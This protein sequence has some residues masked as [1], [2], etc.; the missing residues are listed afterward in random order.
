MNALHIPTL[1]KPYAPLC[2]DGANALLELAR[3]MNQRATIDMAYDILDRFSEQPLVGYALLYAAAR[4]QGDTYDQ[5][6]GA[7]PYLY[8]ALDV[9]WC[10]AFT[11]EIKDG[12]TVACALLHDVLEDHKATPEELNIYLRSLPVSTP[13]LDEQVLQVLLA[14]IRPEEKN[15]QQGYYAALAQAPSEARLIKAADLICNS[16]SLKAKARIW[17][18]VPPKGAPKPHLIAKYIIEAEKYVLDKPAF[19]TLENYPLI[20]NTLLGILQDL[21]GYLDKEAPAQY[22]LLD[23]LALK[24][25]HTGFRSPA[26]HLKQLRFI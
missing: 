9:A 11:L 14:L 7:V 8:H 2:T 5:A 25:Y 3:D 12:F 10:L 1:I 13:E 18:S 17:F 19:Q 26:L 16:A 21:L 6:Y 20:H 24:R 23:Q 22:G 15:D 4:H